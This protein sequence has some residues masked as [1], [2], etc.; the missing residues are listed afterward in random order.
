MQNWVDNPF[1]VFKKKSRI[2]YFD[3]PSFPVLS[4][5]TASYITSSGGRLTA[6]A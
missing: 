4:S 3:A 5:L 2:L 1:S 6:S